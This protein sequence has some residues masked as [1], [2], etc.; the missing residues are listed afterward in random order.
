MWDVDNGV[1]VL[2]NVLNPINVSAKKRSSPAYFY[3]VAQVLWLQRLRA[4]LEVTDVEVRQSVIDETM[5]GPIRAVL[6]LVDQT[7]YEV[8]GEG[9][10]KS[11]RVRKRPED[12]ELE[13]L[14]TF[15]DDLRSNTII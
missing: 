13:Y 3:S 9:D 8:R 5:H 7:R 4:H 6:V 15:A 10:D 12:E 2:A 14:N 1:R 11:L